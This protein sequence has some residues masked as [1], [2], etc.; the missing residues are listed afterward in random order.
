MDKD[1]TLSNL[2]EQA[3]LLLQ[4]ELPPCVTSVRR[5]YLKAVIILMQLR[6]FLLPVF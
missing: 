6:G 5:I 1:Q 4:L 2:I 3:L